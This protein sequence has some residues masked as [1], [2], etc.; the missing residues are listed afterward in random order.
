VGP[1]LIIQGLFF[2]VCLLGPLTAADLSDGMLRFLFLQAV[3]ANPAP[4]PLIAIDEP[5]TGLH[6][7]ML[8][9]VADNAR[10]AADRT[11][12]ILTTHSPEFLDAFRDEPPTTTVVERQDGETQLRV[13]SGE[14]LDYWLQQYT[15]GELYRSSE[16]EA[17]R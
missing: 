7:S 1:D 11:Q 9:I 2:W 17:M 15:L 3:L 6:P 5:E 10:A 12:I 16:L 13:L 8:P 4:P 14:E